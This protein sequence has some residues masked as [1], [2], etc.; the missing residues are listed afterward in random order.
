[1]ISSTRLGCR[2]QYLVNLLPDA[3]KRLRNVL[4]LFSHTLSGQKGTELLHADSLSNQF[5]LNPG[6]NI[7][8]V[9]ETAKYN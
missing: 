2:Y 4:S 3:Y 1:M 7:I 6:Q 8:E 5:S 9:S